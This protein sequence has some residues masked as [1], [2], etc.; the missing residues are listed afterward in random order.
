MPSPTLDSKE[1]ARAGRER[2]AER[3]MKA[4]EEM[5]E[6]HQKELADKP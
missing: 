3:N 4:V 5:V 1:R 6:R 2:L